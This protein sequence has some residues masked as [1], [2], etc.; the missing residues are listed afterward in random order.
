MS[1]APTRRDVLRWA[2]AAAAAP[3]LEAC[4]PK[5]PAPLP[6]VYPKFFTDA[7][8]GALGALV[9]A[10]LPPDDTPGASQLGVVEF[11]D[12]LLTSLEPDA[13]AYFAGGPF[14]GRGPY[15]M[16]DGSPST[17]HPANDFVN[18]LPL[19]RVQ[20][21]AL[22]LFLYGSDGTPGGG[23]NDVL[24]GKTVGLRDQLRALIAKALAANPQLAGADGAGRAAAFKGLTSDERDLLI[25]LT[26]EGAFSAPEYG[27]N[28]NRQGW[29]LGGYEGDLLPFGFTQ[30]DATTGTLTERADRPVSKADPGAEAHPLDAV[31][32]TTIA[33]V[34]S[35]A[36]GQEFK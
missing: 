3:A 15:P 28:V 8:R 24:L 20:R 36:G 18:G 22:Q 1:F 11:V 30:F 31:A 10:V 7:E 25:D 29:A 16:A 21:K 4:G 34:V 12:R 27:G 2:S 14:S 26:C 33:D 9:D 6:V 35:L 5:V 32:R 23:P 19:D 17:L 13:A